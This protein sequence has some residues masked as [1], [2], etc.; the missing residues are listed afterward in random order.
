MG[1]TLLATT[2][3][4][5]DVLG[6]QTGQEG[7]TGFL[8]FATVV[9]LSA[10]IFGK[11][12]SVIATTKAQITSFL[13]AIALSTAA[14][15]FFLTTEFAEPDVVAELNSDS[16]LDFSEKM[17]W[18]PFSDENIDA[19]KADKKPIFIDFTADWCLSCKVNEKNV[20]ETDTIRKAMKDRGIVPVKADWT[21]RD[22]TISRWL[23]EYGKAGVP[24]YL[25]IKAD[26]TPVP[27]PEVLTTNI[28]LNAFDSQP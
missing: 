18:Q 3:W 10:W 2:V 7:V 12:G 4:L 16:E 6:S 21:R 22:E 1:F 23:K 25:F 19:L 9:G 17:P 5:I 28:V 26:G 13:L 24:F 15:F 27:L 20:L 8:A 14:G 11:W